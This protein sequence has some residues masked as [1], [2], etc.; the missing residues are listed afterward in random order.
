MAAL[1]RD[2][3]DQADLLGRTQVDTDVESIAGYL[4]NRRVLVT[5]AG[6]SIGSELCRQIS[7][8]GPGELIMLDRDESAL[9]G[10]QLHVDGRAQLD[11]PDVV[12]A[13]I[14]DATK[15]R[16]IFTE[17]RPEVAF[18]AA[19]LK[20]LPMLEQYPD[21]AWKANVL[22]MLNVLDAPRTRGSACSST[23]PP[24]RP[25]TPPRFWGTPNASP[26]G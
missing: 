19:A 25:P 17:R 21:E 4:T 24:T 26:N 9:H 22:G 6:G 1:L 2:I 15:L 14:R 3:N 20:H 5:G 7:R 13:D 10:T 18:H 23:S 8:F 11:T 12:L 16:R